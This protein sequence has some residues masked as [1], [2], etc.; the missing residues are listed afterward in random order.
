MGTASQPEANFVAANDDHTDP[1]LDP[2]LS[3]HHSRPPF[4]RE[5]DVTA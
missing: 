3:S 2:D 5:L 1:D 4:T